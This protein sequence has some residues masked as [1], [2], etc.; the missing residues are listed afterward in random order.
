MVY[1]PTDYSRSLLLASTATGEQPDSLRAR[2]E[3]H[4]V[5]ISVD[6]NVPGYATTL[7]VLVADLR[8]LPIQLSLEPGK[9]PNQLTDDTIAQLERIAT[10]ID[11]ERP[12]IIGA[13]SSDALHVRIGLDQASADITG[14]PDGYGARLRRPGHPFQPLRHPGNGLGAV[15]TAALLTGEV[16]KTVTALRPNRYRHIDTFDFCPVTLGTP[17]TFMSQPLH[18]ERLMLAGAGAIGT[19]VALILAALG[20]TGDLIV[21]DRQV[22]EMPNVISYSLGTTS[23][24][25][26]RRPKIDIVKTTLSG[27]DVHP[28]YGTI[29][30]V[31]AQIDA[32]K[33]SMPTIVIGA[34]DNIDARYDIQRIYPDLILDGGT[35]GR[36]GTTVGL[37]E[38]L[39]TGPCMRCYF[40]TNVPTSSTV[41]QRL[42]ETTGLPMQRIAYGD[43]PLAP[44]DLVNLTPQQRQRLQPHM[45]KPL[46]GLGRLLGLTTVDGDDTYQPSAA[47]VAQQAASLIVGSLLART[48]SGSHVPIRQVEYDTLF[49]PNPDMADIRQ[50]RPDCYCQTN[51]DTIQKVRAR[52]ANRVYAS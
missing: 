40:P 35:G 42:H 25:A 47:F 34:L 19:A 12:L 11:P 38:A 8:R 21:V 15:L 44:A 52:R 51:A 48:Q 9:R 27:M 26:A 16:F 17:H 41:E 37:H 14:I 39:A 29:D 32:D 13:A 2:I 45:G 18:F 50:P 36:T 23:D 33:V 31:I 30:D 6:T 1:V 10:D 49:G 3:A 22:F 43:Q 20:A 46:C 4:R 5:H 28:V 24:A 7:R